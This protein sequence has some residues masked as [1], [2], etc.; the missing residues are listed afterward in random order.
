M[1]LETTLDLSS[2]R[3]NDQF[4]SSSNER[5]IMPDELFEDCALRRFVFCSI[6]SGQRR[7]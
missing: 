6:R 3:G 7:D 4:F 5:M 1:R 2:H